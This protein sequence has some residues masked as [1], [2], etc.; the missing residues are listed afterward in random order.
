MTESQIKPY[1]IVVLGD[2]AVGKTRSILQ[3]CGKP[4]TGTTTSISVDYYS[5][6]VI[7]D[8]QQIRLHLWDTPGQENFRT[9][10]NLVAREARGIALFFDITRRDS[11]TNLEGWLSVLQNKILE[12]PAETPIVIFGNK[13]DLCDLRTVSE[14]E[15][16]KF[17]TQHNCPYFETSGLTGENLDEAFSTILQQIL[18][19]HGIWPE[20][21]QKPT[22]EPYPKPRKCC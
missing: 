6:E 11:F 3:Y 18:K 13:C 19:L 4:Q 16:R 20:P 21:T 10:S 5:K 2:S 15:A 12:Y 17:A 1:R 9:V 7:M 8:F 14:E 22:P